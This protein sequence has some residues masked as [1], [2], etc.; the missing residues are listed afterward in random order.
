VAG[1]NQGNRLGASALGGVGYLARL[2]FLRY[3]TYLTRRWL[4]RRKFAKRLRPKI[5]TAA[6]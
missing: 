2:R 6:N 1:G 3:L 5:L 4:K